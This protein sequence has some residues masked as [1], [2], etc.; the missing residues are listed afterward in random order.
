M[1]SAE[2]VPSAAILAPGRQR[3]LAATARPSP[4]QRHATAR[5]GSRHAAGLW[6]GLVGDGASAAP[7]VEL[8]G[9]QSD[10]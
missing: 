6:S 10:G 2:Y 3:Y 9:G 4:A 7:R 5:D 1:A 8:S